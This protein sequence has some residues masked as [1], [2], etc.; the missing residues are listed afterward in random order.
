MVAVTEQVLVVS[1]TDKML[2]ETE[3]PPPV[4][5]KVTAPVPLPPVL[6]STAVLPKAKVEGVTITVRGAWSASEA[7]KTASIVVGI[8]IPEGNV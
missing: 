8:F 7:T 2:S 1:T 6:L 5:T 4:A 3:Q